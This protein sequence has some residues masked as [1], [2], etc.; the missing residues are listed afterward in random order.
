MSASASGLAGSGVSSSAP[1]GSAATSPASTKAG[2]STLATSTA[3]RVERLLEA[4]VR[5][6][7][8]GEKGRLAAIAAE[9][10]ALVVHRFEGGAW[11]RIELPTQHRS[12]PDKARLGIYFG[13]DNRL[14]LMGFR[15]TEAGRRMVYQRHRDGRWQDQRSEIGALAGDGAALYGVLGEA[16]PELVCK[17]GGICLIKR[18]S[19]WSEHPA[20]IPEDAVVRAF[21]GVGYA[22]V[23][24]ALWRTSERAFSQI[25]EAGPWRAATGM[26]VDEHGA[27]VVEPATPGAGGRLFELDVGASAWRSG[28][29]PIATPRDVAGQR[30]DRWIVGDEGIAHRGV[31]GWERVGDAALRLDRVIVV[32]GDKVYAAGASGVFAITLSR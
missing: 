7:I 14:R 32:P 22:L 18:R 24:G 20:T 2:P 30:S 8:T 3:Y 31:A 12:A 15:E 13:R 19:G 27:V 26:W 23:P 10:S 6:F 28:P 16:D 25:G 29:A 5:F 4:D 1:A 11:Q 21:G 9:G 17:V